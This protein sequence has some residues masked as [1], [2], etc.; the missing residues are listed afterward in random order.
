MEDY[1]KFTDK[2]LFLELDK[3]EEAENQDN[4]MDGS[5][6]LGGVIHKSY[7]PYYS[8]ISDEIKRRC[9]QLFDEPDYI[10]NPN[11]PY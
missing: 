7:E 2:E 9:I 4:I 3:L 8:A 5:G 1:T 6:E 10:H 11:M